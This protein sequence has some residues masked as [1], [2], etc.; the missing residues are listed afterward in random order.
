MGWLPPHLP[1]LQITPDGQMVPQHP[2]FFGSICVL[3]QVEGHCLT[4]GFPAV[5]VHCPLQQ[6]K[7]PGSPDC[8][9]NELGLR[10]FATQHPLKHLSVRRHILG[11]Q[12]LLQE[13]M[14]HPLTQI[15]RELQPAMQGL[16]TRQGIFKLRHSKM[17]NISLNTST[18]FGPAAAANSSH[19][20]PALWQAPLKSAPEGMPILGQIEFK[21][22]S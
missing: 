3:V 1:L 13:F 17:D 7:N 18:A 5:D 14:Q 2:Q 8:L 12:G 9:Q 10:Q 4:L 21:Q 19:T 22:K 16:L 11:G 20:S 6:G 15:S